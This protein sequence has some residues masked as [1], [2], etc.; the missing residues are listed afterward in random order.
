MH[1]DQSH[2]FESIFYGTKTFYFCDISDIDD[3]GYPNNANEYRNQSSLIDFQSVHGDK[4]SKDTEIL[5]QFPKFK[6]IKWHRVDLVPGDG[7]QMLF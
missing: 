3:L 5:R 4:A 7:K 6:D 1:I 2:N